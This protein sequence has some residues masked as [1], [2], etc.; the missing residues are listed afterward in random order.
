ME[1]SLSPEQDRTKAIV[2]LADFL[3]GSGTL[4]FAYKSAKNEPLEIVTALP[5]A[6]GGILY[7][8]ALGR[9]SLVSH[10]AFAARTAGIVA[11]CIA[12]EERSA[13]ECRRIL[14]GH[15][16]AGAKARPPIFKAAHL[17]IKSVVLFT[18]VVLVLAIFQ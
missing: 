3:I 2:R 12:S 13:P 6:L 1:T 9:R 10:G 4:Y 16:A 11:F 15:F 14:D 17:A 7:L 18:A 5:V 8:V